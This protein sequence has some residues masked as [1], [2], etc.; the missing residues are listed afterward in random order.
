MRDQEAGVWR[1]R[2]AMNLSLRSFVVKTVSQDDIASG[3]RGIT[4]ARL[5]DTA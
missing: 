1:V 2:L 3:R 4:D 5:G